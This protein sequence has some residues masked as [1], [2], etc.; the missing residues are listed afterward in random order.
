MNKSTQHCYMGH[1]HLETAMAYF[2]MTRKGA[3]D[4][5]AIINRLMKGSDNAHA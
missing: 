4:A 1:T 2:H 5:Y 3:E